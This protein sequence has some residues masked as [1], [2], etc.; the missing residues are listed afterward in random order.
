MSTVTAPRRRSELAERDRRRA[1]AAAASGRLSTLAA[2]LLGP[3]AGR[4]R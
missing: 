3:S 2:A 4:G 1:G